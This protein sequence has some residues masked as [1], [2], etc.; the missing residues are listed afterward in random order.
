MYGSFVVPWFILY[1]VVT[2]DAN[3]LSACFVLYSDLLY[4]STMMMKAAFFF[5]IFVD[6]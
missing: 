1:P 3:G 6:F 4:S 5:E 2:Y